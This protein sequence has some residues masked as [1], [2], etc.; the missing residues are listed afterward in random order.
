MSG[1]SKIEIRETTQDRLSLM[2]AQK[3]LPQRSRVQA[4]SLLN[5]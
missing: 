1:V 2:K 5:S 3:Q 4:L